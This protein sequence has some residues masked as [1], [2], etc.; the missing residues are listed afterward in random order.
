[1]AVDG[2]WNIV[3]S[4]PMGERKATLTLKSAG[5]TLTG[6][7]GADGNSTEIFDG[8][9][10]RRRRR[11]ED[12]RHQPDAADAG[13]LRQGF[14]RQHVRRNGHRP[15]GQFSV[16]GDEG[17]N[18]TQAIVITGI[19]PVI[20]ALLAFFRCKHRDG[21]VKPG[22]DDGRCYG[23][24]WSGRR[25]TMAI[26][27]E[28]VDG[29]AILVEGGPFDPGDAMRLGARRN[30]FDHLPFEMNAVAGPHRLQPAEI[31]DAGAE[32]RMRPERT[33][34]AA[35]RMAMAAVCHPEAARP[36]RIVFFAASSSR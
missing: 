29:L 18:D 30:Q 4:T 34:L 25:G 10:S 15:D 24:P 5:G 1:M 16:H 2:N 9:V 8:T 17:V 7:Q 19:D 12:L 23:A 32:Q 28:G 3:M 14:R 13:V 33:A 11:L 35:R 6:T 26:G 31:I 20:H 27:N 21:R 36:P 22:Q